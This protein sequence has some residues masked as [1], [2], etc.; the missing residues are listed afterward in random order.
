MKQDLV[1]RDCNMRPQTGI[2]SPCKI[3]P[4]AGLPRHSSRCAGAAEFAAPHA[5]FDMVDTLYFAIDTSN[6]IASNLFSKGRPRVTADTRQVTET[7]AH[8]EKDSHHVAE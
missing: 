5:V 4:G 1:G 6:L 8:A 2:S 3:R 7:L